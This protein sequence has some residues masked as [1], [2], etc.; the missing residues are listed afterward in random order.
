ML[1]PPA[2]SLSI[3]LL[4]YHPASLSLSPFF[5]LLHFSLPCLHSFMSSLLSSSPVHRLSSLPCFP[6]SFHI[7]SFFSFLSSFLFHYFSLHPYF[8]CHSLLSPRHYS[9]DVLSISFLTTAVVSFTLFIVLPC[10]TFH[11]TLSL[12]L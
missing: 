6:S 10:F 4:I 11:L 3:D 9:S 7:Y 5:H 12:L 1:D 2:I 8:P